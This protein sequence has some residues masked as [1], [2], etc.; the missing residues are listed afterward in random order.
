[1]QDRLAARLETLR[2]EYQTGQTMLAD[3][4]AKQLDLRQTLLRIAGAMQVLEE[5][6]ADA[7][8]PAG[9]DGDAAREAPAGGHLVQAD[10]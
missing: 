8:A 7:E 3:L 10:A 4:E 9:G 5:L 6:L 1:M 2:Q